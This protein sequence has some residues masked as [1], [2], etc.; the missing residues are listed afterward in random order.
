MFDII[1]AASLRGPLSATILNAQ[2]RPFS[3]E[4]WDSLAAKASATT[5]T[6]YWRAFVLQRPTDALCSA[7]MGGKQLFLIGEAFGRWD[8]AS[9]RPLGKGRL[10][11]EAL[12]TSYLRDGNAML[13]A[14]KGNFTLVILDE[15]SLQHHIITSRLAITSVYYAVAE[16]VLYYS[17]SVGALVTA[18]PRS[19]NLDRAAILETA[20]FNFPMGERTFFSGIR[21][22]SQGTV[23]AIAADHVHSRAYW[24]HVDYYGTRQIPM[25]EAHELGSELFFRSVN[26]LAADQ[27][28][29]CASFT[30]GFDSRV[31]HAVL[32]KDRDDVLAYSFG[33]RGSVNVSIPQRICSELGYPFKPIYLDEEFEAVFG[34]YAWRTIILSDGLVVQRANYPYTF[35][36][37]AEFA[38]VVLTGLFGSEFLRTFQNLGTVVSEDFAGINQS[39]RPMDVLAAAMERMAVVSY[40]ASDL[41]EGAREQVMADVE[42]WFGRFSHL[43]ADRRLYM[44]LLTEVDRKYFAGEISTERIYASTR[45]PFLDEEFVEFVFSAPFAGVYSRTIAPTVANRFNSQ[46]FYAYVIR[47]YRPEL[48]GYSTDHGYPPADLL[49]P[50]PILWVGSRHLL[51][52][53]LRRLTN[54]QEF[55]PRKWMTA[56]YEQNS[57]GL[58]HDTGVYSQRF[59]EHLQSGEFL[60][61]LT[62]FDR[63]AALQ[64]WLYH[65]GGH[66]PTGSS[67]GAE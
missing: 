25:A 53:L 51:S 23:T 50:V 24:D 30:S 48:L 1:G 26:D 57:P 64:L 47:K 66:S 21:R 44:Y 42:S 28:R 39:D 63:T 62:S 7:T 19:P 27:R 56:F 49:K 16:N 43:D 15:C 59:R 17:T 22:A 61:H 6:P 31:L 18:L 5:E 35:E 52:R 13:Q 54:Y 46:S 60:D 67:S 37:I 10:S 32:Q 36:Q 45:F 2:A 58:L 9:E 11:A 34:R 38:P 40:L 29:I 4:P 8:A 41:V 33:I 55:R 14:V 20:L 3:A 65:L 12:L